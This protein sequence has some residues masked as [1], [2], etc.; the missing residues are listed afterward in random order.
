MWSLFTMLTPPATASSFTT[1]LIVRVSMGLGEGGAV[2][3]T[4][5][6]I[7]KWFVGSERS[8]MVAFISSGQSV[9][10]ICAMLSA[11]MA[12]WWWPS[13]FYLYG[14][15]GVVWAVFAWKLLWSTPEESPRI[16]VEE[17]EY[18][19][20]E[21]DPGKDKLEDSDSRAAPLPPWQE[22]IQAKPVA[23]I[24][25]AH[26]CNNFGSY[27][28]LSWVP[29]YFAS[30]GVELGSLGFYSV[31]PYVTYFII[32]NV[33][34]SHVDTQISQ[35][36]SPSLHSTPTHNTHRT[37][38]HAT[39]HAPC[40][41]TPT[42]C[43]H[44][45]TTRTTHTVHTYTQHAHHTLYIPRNTQHAVHLLPPPKHPCPCAHPTTCTASSA[46]LVLV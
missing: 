15:F 18:I 25:I 7:A 6:V 45:H 37:Y 23:A 10:T 17:K 39:Q 3:S 20:S 4:H 19:H 1:L 38:I 11:P 30:L 2:P 12:A 29:A 13:V 21:L 36:R 26:V 34:A 9:G 44:P 40:I 5:A 27:V 14:S 32:D 16:S 35:V 41:H 22:L 28:I 46:V 42:H 31:L 43:A 24:I 33:W 8:R